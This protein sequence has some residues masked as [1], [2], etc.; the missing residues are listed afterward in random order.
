MGAKTK[1]RLIDGRRREGFDKQSWIEEADRHLRSAR[2]LRDSRKRRLAAH[3]KAVHFKSNRKTIDNIG[4]MS[5]AVHSSVLLVAY[6]VELFL[7]AGLTRV[8][9]GCSKDLFQRDVKKRYGHDLVKLAKTIEYPLPSTSKR[10]LNEL[11]NVILS[12]GRY[13]FLSE[14]SLLHINR[15][16]GRAARFWSEERFDDHQ[17][18]AH[19]IRT[20]VQKLDA[21]SSD[22]ASF[23]YANIDSDG[24]F[25]FRCGGRLSPRITVRYSSV[26]RLNKTNNKRALKRLVISHF[27]DPILGHVWKSAS[28]RCVKV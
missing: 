25:A 18:L 24:Y 14:D 6:A 1:S 16:N 19:D 21:D 10:Q 22:P 11:Q 5:A 2:I 27:T 17:E 20:H 12:E 28:Y 3:R 26:Q 23:R 8:Y 4:A 9:I 7:K 13:P 15:L